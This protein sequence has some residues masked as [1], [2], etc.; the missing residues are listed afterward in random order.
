MADT[1]TRPPDHRIWHVH[2]VG[3]GVL[4]GVLLT[5]G[6]LGFARSLSFFDVSGG[7]VGGF[8]SNGL[9]S[10]VSVVIGTV[11]I[12]SAF[13]PR[14]TSSW[15]AT[16]VGALFVVA[17]FV[18][19][20]LLDSEAN[21][22]AF[23]LPNVLFSIVSGLALLALGLY[24]RGSGGLDEDNPYRQQREQRAAARRARAAEQEA[25]RSARARQ[26]AERKAERRRPRS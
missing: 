18:N 21:V 5:F 7:E 2:Q 8:S 12:A 6:V 23:E 22:L 17:G 4:G 24:G 19:L 20:A 26:L 16:V 3:C 13:A 14:S 11:L 9:L 10:T 1:S 25:A 15:V